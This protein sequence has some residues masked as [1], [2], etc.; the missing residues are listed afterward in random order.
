M[1]SSWRGAESW[2]PLRGAAFGEQLAG[3]SELAAAKGPQPTGAASG[4]QL[5]GSSWRGAAGGEPLG[6]SWR[7]AGVEEQLAG[8]S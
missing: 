2:Q 7:G 8:S 4:E 5:A 3:S 6:S 1:V